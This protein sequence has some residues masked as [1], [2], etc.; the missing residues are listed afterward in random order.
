MNLI[1]F[2]HHRPA[3]Y[4]EDPVFDRFTDM[5]DRIFQ[6]NNDYSAVNCPAANVMEQPDSYLIEMA[7]PGYDRENINIELEKNELSISGKNPEKEGDVYTYR[8]FGMGDFSRNFVLPQA[9]DPEKIDAS[10]RDGILTVRIGKREE[11]IPKPPRQI[12]IN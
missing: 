4:R 11:A 9:A 8:E 6:Y 7:V 5:I 10:F 3:S 2:N 12:D 1:R